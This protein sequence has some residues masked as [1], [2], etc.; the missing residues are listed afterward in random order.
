ML[1]YAI[2]NC[3]RL[4]PLLILTI[5]ILP[6]CSDK[7]GVESQH[8]ARE[9]IARVGEDMI[10]RAE[11]AAAHP[12]KTVAARR[13]TLDALIDNRLAVH[14]AR[15]RG[16]HASKDLAAKIDSIHME[17]DRKERELLRDA[18]YRAVRVELATPE[19]ELLNHYEA[20][21][22]RYAE[23]R[24]IL[25]RTP[26]PSRTE[27]TKALEEDAP[28]TPFERLGPLPLAKLSPSVLPEAA[29][30]RKT[31][32]RRLTKDDDGHWSVIELVEILDAEPRAFE[33][34]RDAVEKNYR[35]R[36][37]SAALRK[38][39]DR[40]RQQTTIAIDEDALNDAASWR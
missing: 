39:L 20:T 16:L 19:D 37:G 26:Y 8:S 9:P 30:L 7:N 38:I 11:L 10:S 13:E 5:G 29:Y 3:F 17:A 14:E 32:E 34:V 6:G 27:A 22:R 40:L 18:L 4:A 21:K 23:R 24:I 2:R 12:G 35:V 31:G 33:E 28:E 25:D 15:R 1:L 36:K